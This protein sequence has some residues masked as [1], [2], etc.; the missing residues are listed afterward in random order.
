MIDAWSDVAEREGLAIIA[1]NGEN[2]SWNLTVGIFLGDSDHIFTMDSGNKTI[3]WLASLGFSARLYILS[4]HNHW[5]YANAEKINRSIWA[6]LDTRQ[7]AHLVFGVPHKI[8]TRERYNESRR[9][10]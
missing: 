3:R 8:A 4:E 9:Q 1:P 10:N 2:I 7:P 5:Y 6:F